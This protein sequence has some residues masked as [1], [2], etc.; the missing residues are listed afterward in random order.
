[1]FFTGLIVIVGAYLLGSVNFAVIFTKLF[2]KKDVRDFGSGNAGST[3]ALRVGGK[4]TGILTFVCDFL[5]GA[6]S[7]YIGILIFKYINE[8]SASVLSKPIYGAY[9]CG[10]ACMLGHIFPIYFGFRGGKGVATGL[11]IFLACCPLSALVGALVF[12]AVVLATRTVSISSL[13]ATISVVTT[14]LVFY[15]KTASFAIQL[16]LSVILGAIVF[17]KHKENI[18]R[19]INKT[20]NK[21]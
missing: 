3:N 21:F 8:N 2:N 19:V 20:E 6:V 13:I 18:V 10:L 11:G 1:M 14:S 12:V 7:S 17:V 4:L 5:K 16:V 15:D 9:L